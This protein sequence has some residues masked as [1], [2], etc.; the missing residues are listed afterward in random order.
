ML[1]HSFAAWCLLAGLVTALPAAAHAAE[2]AALAHGL[3]V[4]SDTVLDKHL[5]P[6]AR[7]QM[8]L[9]GLKGLLAK[10][11]TTV[12]LD[13][14][15]RVSQVTTEEQFAALLR[16]LC[17]NPKAPK[18]TSLEEILYNSAL[19]SVSGR[20]H[21][22]PAD[23]FKINEAASA[24]RYVGTGIQIRKDPK[25]DFIQIVLPFPGGPARKAGA[26]PGD[27]IVEVD[28]ESMRGLSV[29]E[30]VKKLR[31]DEGTA[32][33]MVVR[34]PEATETRTLKMV[35]SVI[36]FTSVAGFRRTGEESWDFRVDAELPIAY[37]RVSS[38]S[39]STAHELRKL[40]RQLLADGTRA[41]ILDLRGNPGGN[42]DHAALVADGLLDNGPLWRVRH[43][44]G[45]VK[46]Y[47]ADRDCW[48]RDCSL[49]VLVDEHTASAAALIAAAL[50]DNGRAVLIGEKSHTY[51]VVKT[52]LALP[53]DLGG[54]DLVTGTVERAKPKPPTNVAEFDD[55]TEARPQGYQVVPDHLVKL[56]AK[57]KERWL[58]WV[59]EQDLPEPPANAEKNP[60]DDPQLAKALALLREALKATETP[61]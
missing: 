5:D 8:L 15:Q 34:Q 17:P 38:I 41:V 24:N 42:L 7:Q 46:E 53:G 22:V 19:A 43:K 47:K 58:K 14:P 57:Q 50:Q 3:W 13:L 44:Q 20:P 55:E 51:G 40:E 12:P 36:P 21:I 16:D 29:G 32:V 61:R 37:L 28:G 33:T 39:I 30:V 10:T 27:L 35:R 45:D 9:D 2:P 18:D 25:E 1:R 4:I 23:M 52:R 59:H 6:P 48:F 11:G 54:M 31:G 26:K 49:A 60:P 56:D